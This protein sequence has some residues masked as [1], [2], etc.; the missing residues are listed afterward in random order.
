[1]TKLKKARAAKASRLTALLPP[2]LS[3]KLSPR[4]PSVVPPPVWAHAIVRDRL[5]RMIPV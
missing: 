2:I 1:M 5:A 4:V 3:E